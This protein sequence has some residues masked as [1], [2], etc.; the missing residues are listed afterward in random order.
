MTALVMTRSTCCY[1]TEGKLLDKLIN[2]VHTTNGR[3]KEVYMTRIENVRPG[4]I[5]AKGKIP[6]ER[7]GDQAT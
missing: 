3:K 1:S 4:P 6:G 2:N 7:K 5:L